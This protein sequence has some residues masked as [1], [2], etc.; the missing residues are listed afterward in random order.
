LSVSGALAAAV[1][2]AAE[3]E[4]VGNSIRIQDILNFR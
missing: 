2:A 4:E 3:P 1:L